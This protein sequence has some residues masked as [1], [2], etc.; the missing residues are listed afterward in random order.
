MAEILVF[1]ELSWS[2]LCTI[3]IGNVF[4]GCLVC[5][6]TNWTLLAAV[7]MLSSAAGAIANGLCYYVYYEK[8]PPKSTAVASVFSDIFWLLQEAGL[9][10]YS[11]I[12]LKRVLQGARWRVFSSLFWTGIAGVIIVR[13]III[14]FRVRSILN[15]NNDLLATINHI[16]I[17]YFG[18]IA[19]LECLSAY[20]LL[21]LFTSARASSVEIARNGG[22]FQYLSRSTEARVA[23]LALQGTFRA[24]THS[25]KTAGQTAENIATQLDR[26]TY[27]LF[28]LYS[29]VLYIDLLS[30]KLKFNITQYYPYSRDRHVHQNCQPGRFTSTQK[31]DFVSNR[32]EHVVGVNGGTSKTRNDSTDHIIEGGSSE[33]DGSINLQDM[34]LKGNVI[35][36]TVEFRVV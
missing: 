15:G 26:F 33:T 32:T 6:I 28:C 7:P 17:A 29:M 9:L 22:L 30:S 3:C 1:F 19:M 14:V 27:A 16:H 31:D 36:K 11:Y 21:V 34:D 24:I 4:L 25:F 10:F 18:L 20:F 35:K 23:L 12:I 5:G 2:I 13:I 8:H